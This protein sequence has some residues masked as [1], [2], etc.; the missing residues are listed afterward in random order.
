MMLGVTTVESF[1]N[2]HAA[3]RIL[4][5]HLK[6]TLFAE[7]IAM[8][9]LWLAGLWIPVGL[10]IVAIYKLGARR[11]SGVYCALIGDLISMVVSGA[12]TT[13]DYLLGSVMGLIAAVM[14][15]IPLFKERLLTT[16]EENKNPINI[17]RK[18]RFPIILIG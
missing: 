4:Y 13:I 9:F 1:A 10:L 11:V 7:G 17:R 5:G 18:N 16:P 6:R 3:F 12:V 8:T 14:V 2:G 15:L